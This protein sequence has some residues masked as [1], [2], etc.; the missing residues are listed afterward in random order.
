[1]IAVENDMMKRLAFLEVLEYIASGNTAMLEKAGLSKEAIKRISKAHA[2]DVP[3]LSRMMKLA[4][5][6]DPRNLNMDFS[7]A[8]LANEEQAALEYYVVNHAT[9][10][11]LRRYFR[12]LSEK[13]IHSL[14]TKLGTKKMGRTPVLD[15][16][17]AFQVFDA[18]ERLSKLIKDERQRYIAL[19]KDFTEWP[20]SALYSAINETD[21]G[22][23]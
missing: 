6:V 15:N 10:A 9:P 13:D 1:M 11:M 20:L 16:R 19:H 3:N 8:E 7:R 17:T 2:K 14:R 23:E 12:T 22:A 18:W 4:I 21:S 5:T